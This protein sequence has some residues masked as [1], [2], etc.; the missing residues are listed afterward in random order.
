MTS[1]NHRWPS[2]WQALKWDIR[3][4]SSRRRV[5][6][7]RIV[8]LVVT[9]VS[10]LNVAGCAAHVESKEGNSHG[11]A[12]GHSDELSD[13]AV[14][15]DDAANI[16]SVFGLFRNGLDDLTRSPI[17]ADNQHMARL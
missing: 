13:G 10:S 15:T 12:S 17:R 6:P 16:V 7:F 4:E 2:Q 11:A 3:A 5:P 1:A 9:G 8:A 14:V